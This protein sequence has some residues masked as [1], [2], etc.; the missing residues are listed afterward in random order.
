[1]LSWAITFLIIAIVAAVLGF[2]GNSGSAVQPL[3]TS[4]L[5]L[6]RTPNVL[7][8]AIRQESNPGLPLSIAGR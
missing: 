6:P 7:E 3:N 4:D 1:M 8:Q 5:L 2:G